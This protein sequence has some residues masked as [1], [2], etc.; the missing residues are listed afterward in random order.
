[1]T[2]IGSLCSGAGM[3]DLAV[4]EVLG[5]RIAWHADTDPAAARV[6]DRH[7]PGMPNHGDITTADWSAVKSVDVITAGWPCQPWSVAGQRKGHMDERAIWP[8]IARVVRLLRPDLIVLENVSAVVAAGELARAVADLAS[9]GYVGSWTCV[10]ASAVG[11][12]HRRERLFV[13]AWPAAD[14]GSKG[15]EIRRVEHHGPQRPAAERDRHESSADTERGRRDGR[16]AVPEPAGRAGRG[17]AAAGAA[18]GPSRWGRW[19]AAIERWERLTRPAPD[20]VELGRRGNWRLNPAFSEWMMGLPAGWV[21]AV[22]GLSRNDQL[23]LIG[24][25]CVPRQV[26]YALRHLLE[27]GREEVPALR[28]AVRETTQ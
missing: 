27:V 24:N 8:A 5:G 15:L 25:G 11:A 3:L 13:V 22:P 19:T 21:T 28:C 14:A 16:P 9:F 4:L 1:M 7:W 12:P 17:T 20:P 6:L 10:P 23:R 2:Q 26:E 18:D